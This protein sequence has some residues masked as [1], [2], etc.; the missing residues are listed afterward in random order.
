VPITN[1]EFNVAFQKPA[2][3]ELSV[4]SA[5]AGDAVT[6]YGMRF[7]PTDVILVAGVA[8]PTI[9]TSDTV[10]S[11]VVPKTRGG[12]QP[13]QVRQQDGTLSNRATLIVLP[14]VLYAEQGGKK[15]TDATPPHFRPGSMV[16]IVG[17][18]F[19]PDSRVRV[20]DQDVSGTDVL[21]VDEGRLRFKVIRPFSTPVTPENRDG[22][23]VSIKVILA[24]GTE[25][26]AITIIL[27]TILILVLGDS[28]EWGQGLVEEKKFFTL[29]ANEIKSRESGIGVYTQVLAHS[30]ATIGAQVDSPGGATSLDGEVPRG[31]P[32]IWQQIHNFQGTKD[33]VDYVLIDGGI[34]DV[35]V[36]DIVN[37]F[38]NVSATE[39][40][41]KT[42]ESCFTAMSELLKE[43]KGEF[44]N[45]QV[46]VTGYYKII[47]SESDVSGLV[48][49]LVNLGFLAVG[50]EGAI[51]AAILTAVEVGKMVERSRIFF[52]ESKERLQQ[53]VQ[54]TNDAVTTGPSVKF[55]QPPFGD[56][57]ALFAPNSWLWGLGL[58]LEPEDVPPDGVADSRAAA[59]EAAGD[60]TQSVDLCK[61]ASVGHPNVEGA[62]RYANAIIAVL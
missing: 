15:S 13:V 48:A 36:E 35:T 56:E 59:C 17:T 37:P 38:S 7:T 6:A 45:A 42:K 54:A 61:R 52:E 43:V 44:K 30:G 26:N 46:I 27:D 5:K 60:Q 57:N 16:D 25:S 58:S 9:V 4:P 23:P 47:S 55:A 21:F 62:S 24:E 22:E 50:V 29:V 20:I 10:L 32:T 14:V 40:A 19:A 2:I 1:D 33:S 28:I 53:A 12:I 41:A 51:A 18:G 49:L 3:L 8:C 39:L 31:S 34:N 11:F